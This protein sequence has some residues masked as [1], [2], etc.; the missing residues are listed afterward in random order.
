MASD[1]AT[2]QNSRSTR[3]GQRKASLPTSSEPGALRLGSG[4]GGDNPLRAQAV[5]GGVI[6]LVLLAVPLYLLRR[7][8]TQAAVVAAATAPSAGGFGGVVRDESAAD[9]DAGSGS[10]EV[11]LGPVQRVRCGSSPRTLA[12]EGSL[13]DALPSLERALARAIEQNVEC[14][15]RTSKG[16]TLN[17][18]LEV[19]FDRRHVSMFAGQ[20]GSWKG[21]QARTAAR[22][23]L[24]QLP[25]VDWER[26]DHQY[27]YYAIAIL[28]TYPAPDPLEELPVFD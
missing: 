1:D 17:Y 24:R 19:D 9:A 28:G 5:I 11:T 6:A 21:P 20:S 16:G 3:P 22:C 7:P 25:A 26:I 4:G 23:V 15:P 27:R 2:G 8:A 12:A 10:S 14:A 18:V 13:C